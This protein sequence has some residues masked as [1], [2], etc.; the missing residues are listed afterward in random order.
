M[1]VFLQGLLFGFVYIAP[2]GMQNLFVVSTA[3]EQPLKRAIRVALIVILFDTSL[4][5]A[6]FYGVGKILQSTPWLELTVLLVGSL[7]VFYIG[8]SLLKQKE[9]AM[10]T[11]DTNFSY[12]TA[13]I[14]A[15]SVAWLNPQALIDGSVLLAAFRVSLPTNL[16]HFFMMGVIIASII[17]FIGLTGVI[18]KFKHLM[19]PRVLLWI[20]RVC[21]AVIIL[22]GVKLLATFVTKI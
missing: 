6:C 8:W 7:L 19:Q 9:A 12:K 21:G 4:S 14:T 2:I 20:N 1:Q 5:L 10:D 18:S 13:I 15:F 17:W 16:T 22:Y 11:M 3:I